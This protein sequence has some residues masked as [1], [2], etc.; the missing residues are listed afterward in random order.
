[1]G[2]LASLPFLFTAI[3]RTNI[4]A[5]LARFQRSIK[6][7]TQWLGFVDHYHFLGLFLLLLHEKQQLFLAPEVCH[8]SNRSIVDLAR[9]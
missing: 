7:I 6:H 5:H 3:R 4:A 2:F 1:M 9:P 8:R